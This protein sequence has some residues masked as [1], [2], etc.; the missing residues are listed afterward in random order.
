MTVTGQ[1]NTGVDHHAGYGEAKQ[2]CKKIVVSPRHRSLI[3]SNG[4]LVTDYRGNIGIKYNTVMLEGQA[5]KYYEEFITNANTSAK[6]Y[7]LNTA[8]WLIDHASDK[9]NYSLWEYTFPWPYYYCLN[10]PYSSALAQAQGMEV[11]M[12]AHKISHNYKYIEAAKKSFGSFLIDY[13]QGGVVTKMK[14]GSLIFQELAKPTYTR[15]DVLNGHMFAILSLLKYYDYTHDSLVKEVA[16][17]GINYLKNYMYTY[18]T[19]KWSYFDHTHTYAK[20]NY[21]LIHIDLL[22]KLYNITGE[23]T[24]YHYAKKF[25]IYYIN[26][27]KDHNIQQ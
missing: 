22:Q 14:D 1:I 16:D 13:E 8:D 19:G 15:S 12:L 25:K 21:H 27:Q 7:L 9:G 18:D 17:N 23:S 3:D 11:L 10:P 20:T 5:L 24:F 6:K 4:I 2:A 26:S